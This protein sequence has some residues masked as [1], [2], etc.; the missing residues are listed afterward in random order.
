MV[1]EVSIPTN[2]NKIISQAI[3]FQIS[4]GGFHEQAFYLQIIKR[5][6]KQIK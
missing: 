5:K 2:F 6:P 3:C 4:Y 1:S